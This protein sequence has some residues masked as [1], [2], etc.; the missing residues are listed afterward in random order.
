[1][2]SKKSNIKFAVVTFH[3]K[4]SM[5]KLK[6]SFLLLFVLCATVSFSQFTAP[7]SCSAVIG[8]PANGPAHYIDVSWPAVAGATAYELE[9]STDGVIW[10]SLYTGTSPFYNHNTGSG[11]NLPYWYQVRAFQNALFSVW[12]PST[13]S[14]TYSA[15]N[16]PQ[17]PQLSNAGHISLDLNLIPPSPDTNTAYTTYSIYCTTDSLFLQAN[18]TLAATEIFQTIAAWGTVHVTGLFPS[19]SYCFYAKARNN[20]GDIRID[21]GS[22]FS[23]FEDWNTNVLD[24]TALSPTNVWW[25]SDTS[26]SP[27]MQY[28]ASGG[29][30]GGN[31]GFSGSFNN[32]WSSFLRS[33]AVN[34]STVNQLL[35]SLSISNSYFPTHP[36]DQVSF[37][38]FAPTVAF[39]TGTFVNAQSVNGILGNVLPFDSVRNCQTISVRYD[40][41]AVTDKSA[42][43]LY[44]NA[45]CGYNDADTFSV[46]ID[47]TTIG[48]GGVPNTSCLGTTFCDPAV[49]QTNPT[50]KTIC[51]NGPASFVVGVTGYVA[52]YQWQVSIDNGSTW[53]N[54]TN[55]GVYFHPTQ[56]V[57]TILGAGISM[58]GYQYRCMV[59]DSC[60]RNIF[61]GVA[62]L[63]VDSLQSGVTPS[64]VNSVCAGQTNVIYTTSPF[65]GATTY[66]WSL[67]SGVSI[68][69]GG[70]SDTVIVNFGNNAQTGGIIATPYNACGAGLPSPP[71]N[72]TVND[73]PPSPLPIQGDSMPC[74]NS[75]QT[76]S[77]LPVTGA[78][79][80]TWTL[81]PA[82]IGSSSVDSIHTSAVASTGNITVTAN[83]ACGSSVPRVL[84]VTVI[85]TNPG[86]PGVITGPDTICAGSH[87]GYS[88]APVTNA[89]GY[90]WALPNSWNGNSNIDSINLIA[91]NATGNITVRAVNSCG[92]SGPRIKNVVVK[93]APP[94]VTFNLSGG[95]VCNNA[96]NITLNTGTPPGGLYSGPG[97]NNGVFDPSEGAIGDNII[98]YSVG[99]PGCVSSDTADLQVKLCIGINDIAENITGVFPNPFNNYFTVTM[100]GIAG[101]TS[102]KLYDYTGREVGSYEIPSDANSFVV[103]TS[104]LES[105]VY[106]LEIILDGNRI[107]V[108]KLVKA[109]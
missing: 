90:T 73:P 14:P 87:A 6:V 23:F 96:A 18:G 103:N 10:D 81:P 52:A 15:A 69:S 108:K 29:C 56:A 106:L 76:Y 1:M 33:P 25:S 11:G 61:S 51:S 85:S 13:P 94:I 16:V 42:V 109:E 8:S 39:P 3:T 43:L 104:N 63:T 64:G 20:D 55:G 80:Y 67:P 45:M 57:L 19:T 91:G 27:P 84:F 60:V 50:N 41:S 62:L 4:S 17:V 54:I 101:K 98:T 28:L 95:P 32:Q 30:P 59:T 79:S 34:C 86:T 68:V 97:V 70:T 7:A 71:L 5:H 58:N 24:T 36:N 74:R 47:N 46:N 44:I 22:S 89:N 40:L 31:V 9:Y 77:V 78:L 53:S 48:G 2:F 12:V 72:I 100:S 88:V 92:S 35:F 99:V 93:P 38:L 26:V 75:A 102:A 105:G 49:I 66:T 37:T 82:W 21:E 65:D 83:N 107:A